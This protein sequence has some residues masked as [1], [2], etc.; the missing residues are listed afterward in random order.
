MEIKQVTIVGTGLIGGSL[1]LVF[2]QLKDKP[3][4]IGFSK[5]K[6]TLEKAIERGAVD[7]Y[8]DSLEEA[9]SG[10]DIVFICTPVGKIVEI[11]T[12]AAPHMKKDSVLT[13]VGSTKSAIVDR[14]E[15]SLPEGVYFIGGHPMAGSESYGIEN[16]QADLFKGSRYI[17]TPTKKTNTQAFQLLHNLLAKTGAN[18]I[19][20]DADKHDRIVASVSHLPHIIAASLVNLVDKG[21]SRKE[22][23]LDIAAGGFKD[24][25]RIAAGSPQL[26]L[27]ICLENKTAIVNALNE[28]KQIINNMTDLIETE[29]RAALQKKLEQ[30][31]D[32]RISMATV[33]EK[34]FE[35]FRDLYVSVADKPGVISE[36]TLAIG[37]LG[38]NIEDIEILHSDEMS[39]DL[40]ISIIG[41]KEAE[42]AA[43]VLRKS[44]YSV[45]VR[46]LYE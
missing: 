9:V 36:I 12:L 45:I 19:A 33:T 3:K 17:L 37:E 27:D 31:R 23:W 46:A 24:T 39:G 42:K 13:D 11:A 2:K 40:R 41:K 18:V 10:S 6:E 4:I 38:L 32:A 30:A 20:I 25:T 44:G 26:W 8:R 28:F 43:D 5:T 15:S 21:E 16:A 34:E 7:E 35:E 14:I 1:G 22:N 29:D